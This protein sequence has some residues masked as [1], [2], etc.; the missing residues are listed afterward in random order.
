MRHHAILLLLC[1]LTLC[2]S[3][4]DDVLEP[5]FL[6][7]GWKNQTS[8]TQGDLVDVFFYDNQYGWALSRFDGIGTTTDGGKNWTWHQAVDKQLYYAS[9]VFF[10]DRTNGW[11]TT[12]EG[13]LYH[14]VD[15]GITWEKNKYYEFYSHSRIRNL[16]FVDAQHGWFHETENL[17]RTVDGGKT[18]TRKEIM[19]MNNP[20][21]L[22]D[23]F[24]LDA[25]RGWAVGRG[26]GSVSEGVILS[27]T[28]G[29]E[30][31]QQVDTGEL[32]DLFFLHFTDASTGWAVGKYE[33]FRTSDGGQTWQ[34]LPVGYGDPIVD[35]T[36]IGN[37]GWLLRQLPNVMYSSVNYPVVSYTQNGGIT[38][39]FQNKVTELNNRTS[40]KALYFTD[41]Q[42]GWVVG[43]KGIIWHTSTGGL[44]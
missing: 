22:E 30:N 3:C 15:G 12:W 43:S 6:P 10:L 37:T 41:A 14:S 1:G 9:E 29:G 26:R 28:D 21:Q 35:I 4:A 16:Q 5:T 18:W 40:I 31:W 44:P 27:T 13:S 42:N 17:F 2:F 36:F 7:T 25:Q 20:Y 39:A 38:W 24:F 23:I 34:E 32:P 8:G 11:V 19:P 33:M